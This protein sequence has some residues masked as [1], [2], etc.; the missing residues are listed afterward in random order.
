MKAGFLSL[1][2]ELH[3]QII[4]S[5]QIQPS[6]PE[7]Q[8]DSEDE[9]VPE[10]EEDEEG[11]SKEHLVPEGLKALINLS[12]TC[13]HMR[14]LVGPHI[15]KKLWLTNTD[16]SAASIKAVAASAFRS[17]VKEL[18]FVG[19]AA[20]EKEE[21]FDS[22]DNVL[23]E[24]TEDILSNLRVYFP[25]LDSLNIGFAWELYKTDKWDEWPLETLSGWE[26]DERAFELEEEEAYRALIGKVWA[27]ISLNEAGIVKSLK[28]R[29][30]VPKVV[31][32]FFSPQFDLFL[33]G[34]EKFH[35]SMWGSDNAGWVS[36]VLE[37]YRDGIS[38]L[39]D[40]LKGLTSC[41]DFTFEASQYG[42]VGCEGQNHVALPLL[43]KQMP[44]LKRLTLHHCF[45][46]PELIEFLKAHSD[47]IEEVIMQDCGASPISLHGL[48]DNGI[49]WAEL[50]S[51]MQDLKLLKTFEL[52]P[53]D[54]SYS[55]EMEYFRRSTSD[56]REDVEKVRKE[57]EAS[58]G[59]KRVFAYGHCKF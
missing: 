36:G 26:D 39:A 59:Q 8:E 53:E 22:V 15:F 6:D 33:S 3:L 9:E 49:A 45:A 40:I 21:D 17:E 34:V 51:G 1:S 52:L 14:L 54:V 11:D 23:P 16:S 18:L 4:E 25:N 19:H 46:S 5:L 43:P 47:T 35:I 48:A 27:A 38:R 44:L 31:S 13:K 10:I 28:M 42:W 32:T 57:L 12:C 37:G 29:H 50:F 41:I 30:F 20:G 2:P 58:N 56:D 7:D 55:W 24:E